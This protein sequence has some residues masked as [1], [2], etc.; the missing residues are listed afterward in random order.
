M[1]IR[2]AFGVALIT[3]KWLPPCLSSTNMCVFV[4]II[5]RLSETRIAM[6]YLY[7]AYDMVRQSYY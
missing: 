5:L 3:G 2:Y 7:T 4:E 6:E 1:A